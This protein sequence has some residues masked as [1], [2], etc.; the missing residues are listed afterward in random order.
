MSAARRA[1]SADGES[2]GAAAGFAAVAIGLAAALVP[3][4]SELGGANAA[5]LMVGVTVAAAAVGGRVA[6]VTAAIAA[7]LSF[8]FFYTQP[9]LTL[10]IHSGRDILTTLLIV[11]VGLGVGELGVAR[12]RQSATRRV[13]LRS[14]RRLEAVG[15]AVSGGAPV[16]EVW[17]GVRSAVQEL[18][19]ARSVSFVA[20][21]ERPAVPVIE[22]DGRIDTPD[23]VLVGTGFALPL[24]G[25]TLAVAADGL[26]LGWILVSTDPSVAVSREQRRT[27]VAVADQFAIVLRSLPSVQSMT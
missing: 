16:P 27:A 12:A 13:Q 10:R 14:M 8:N 25:V 20:G 6:G 2:V 9:Y 23:R 5:L 24:K 15:A 1:S 3:L 17:E 18:L 7:S 26:D 11:V 4:R 21:A 22:R 19:A